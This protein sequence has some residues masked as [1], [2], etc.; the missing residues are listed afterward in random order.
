MNLPPGAL[1]MASVF[2]G[3]PRV[4][5]SLKSPDGRYLMVNQAFADRASRKTAAAVVGRTAAD[6]FAPELATSYAAQDAALLS[7]GPPVRRQ[8]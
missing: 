4:M 8:L 2:E 7:G 5:F 3:L 6:L 1:D